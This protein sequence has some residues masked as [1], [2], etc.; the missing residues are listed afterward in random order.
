MFETDFNVFV[1]ITIIMLWI[2]VFAIKAW[3]DKPEYIPP[4]PAP[5]LSKGQK[6]WFKIY[7]VGM[8]ILIVGLL[9]GV[10]PHVH[11]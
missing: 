6:L 5:S 2:F 10:I 11:H 9:S 3:E 7:G 8:V 1:V 4:T